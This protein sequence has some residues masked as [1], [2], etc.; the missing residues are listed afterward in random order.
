MGEAGGVALVSSQD[1][2]YKI[3]KYLINCFCVY[4]IKILI[5]FWERNSAE[6]ATVLALR[7]HSKLFNIYC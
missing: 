3:Y 5:Y 1:L 7:L 6:Q 4:R 2:K